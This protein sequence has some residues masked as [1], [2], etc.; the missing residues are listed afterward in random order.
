MIEILKGGDYG[1]LTWTVGKALAA[2]QPSHPGI[3]TCTNEDGLDTI[4]DTIRKARVHRLTIVDESN[5]LKG[6]LSLS[7]ILQYMLVDGPE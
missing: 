5:Y 6:V 4:L 7:D 3:Y 2:R 1:N